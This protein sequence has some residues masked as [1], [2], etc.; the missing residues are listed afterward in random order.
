MIG[1]SRGGKD[2]QQ[3]IPPGNPGV[4]NLGKIPHRFCG[5]IQRRF[6]MVGIFG[7]PK[8]MTLTEIQNALA[9]LDTQPRQSLGQNFLHD[10]NICKWIA[11]QLDLQPGDHVVEVGPGLGSL[12]ECLAIPGVKLT[13]IEKDGKMVE[14]LREKFDPATVEMFHDD[15][16]KFD[17][18]TLYGKGPVKFA[19]N[20]PYYVSTPLIAKYASALSP[21]SILVL[22]LQHEVAARLCAAPGT[23]DFGAMT[24]CVSRRWDVKYLRKIA[25]SVFY[26]APQVSSAVVIFTRKPASEVSPCDDIIFE[27]LVRRG[28]AERRKKLRNNLPEHK[29]RW[30]EI[31]ELLGV[32]ETVRA[33]E[34]TLAQWEEFARFAQPAGAQ[35]GEEIFDVVDEED[36]IVGKDTRSSVHVNNLR[37]RAVHMLIS[38]QEG[39]LFLQKRS[40]WKDKNPGL[41]DSSAAGHVDSGETYLQAAERELSEELGIQAPLESIGRLPCGEDTG[42]EFIEVFRATHEGPFTFPAMEIETGAFFPIEQVREWSANYPADFSPVFLQA[43]QLF[44]KAL[45]A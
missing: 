24:I 28:F 19:S 1:I 4:N 40:I 30:L 41:W 43:F 6:V 17:L 42:W 7:Y 27:S 9:R 12:S 20:L 25:G 45:K 32:L 22:M 44:E 38:N 15:A 21:A 26:P 18:R 14:W 10:Q 36:R 35:S 29:E 34:L 8:C 16:L 5:N 13:L 31:C 23:K 2:G 37:H 3:V 39:E 11:A 33:E